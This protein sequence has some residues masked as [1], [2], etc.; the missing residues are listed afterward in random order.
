[1]ASIRSRAAKTVVGALGVKKQLQAIADS[2]GDPDVFAVR[3][4]KAR[5]SDKRDPPSKVRKGRTY[6]QTEL[7]GSMLVELPLPADTSQRT[8]LYLHGGGYLTGPFA[9]E[10][11]M[12]GNLA[13]R[14]N[15]DLAV[16][17][18]PRAPEHQAPDTVEAAVEAFE[19]SSRAHG[20]SRTAVVGTSSGGGLAVA[21]M[22]ELLQRGSPLPAAAILISPAVDMALSEDVA[23]L[24]DRDVLLSPDFV[25]ASGALYAGEL[26][27]SHPWVSPTNGVLTGLPPISVYVGSDEILLPSIETFADRIVA[28]GGDITV[29]IGEGQQHTYPTAPVPEGHQ[30]R[31]HIVA[32]INNA[33]PA[34]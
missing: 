3:L 17:L 18:Y 11:S 28:A 24:A 14:T 13:S 16:L 8:I 2:V 27:V 9:P 34:T 21:M 6:S 22:G 31:D 20:A 33:V 29:E 7:S 10:W 25:R 30:A 5:R 4:A 26:G 23:H 15:S 1:M 19:I 32:T 12:I